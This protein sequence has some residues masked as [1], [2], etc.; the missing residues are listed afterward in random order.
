MRGSKLGDLRFGPYALAVGNRHLIPPVPPPLRYSTAHSL[1]EIGSSLLKSNPIVRCV[2]LRGKG[3]WAD[4][5]KWGG[6]LCGT[7]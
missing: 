3:G 5:W 7:A 4:E 2:H 6:L 1:W